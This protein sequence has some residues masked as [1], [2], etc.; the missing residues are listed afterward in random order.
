MSIFDRLLATQAPAAVVLIRLVIGGIFLSEGMQKFL[1]PEALGAGRFL[2]IGIPSPD[3]TAPFVGICEI[4][5]GMLFILGLFTRFAAVT[6]IL[7][8]LVAIA[9][10]KIPMLHQDGFWKMA[11]EARTDY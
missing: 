5:S 3:L 8:M 4:V 11:H 6:M 9:T 1:F 7:N 10:T 2:K